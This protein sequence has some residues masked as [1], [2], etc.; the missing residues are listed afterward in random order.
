MYGEHVPNGQRKE[1]ARLK[2]IDLRD[3]YGSR[4]GRWKYP[5]TLLVALERSEIVG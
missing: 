1:L 5:S 3:G 4:V 2:F